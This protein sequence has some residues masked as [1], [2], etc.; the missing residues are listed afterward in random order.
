MTS[1]ISPGMVQDGTCLECCTTKKSDRAWSDSQKCKGVSAVDALDLGASGHVLWAATVLGPGSTLIWCKLCGRHAETRVKGLA[2]KCPKH[3]SIQAATRI[4]KINKSMH[5]VLKNV[6]L[7]N[8]WKYTNKIVESSGKQPSLGLGGSAEVVGV[9]PPRQVM[10]PDFDDS[11]GE[12]F[13]SEE[14]CMH[15]HTGEP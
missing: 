4:N 13:W 3:M 7:S 5:P 10:P 12:D 15:V 8:P 1:T 11:E 9:Q 2:N 14:D 6:R